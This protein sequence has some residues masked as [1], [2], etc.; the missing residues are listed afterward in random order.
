MIKIFTLYALSKKYIKH[1]IKLIFIL[2]INFK[3]WFIL[4]FMI[5]L[6][7]VIITMI[8]LSWPFLII[9]INDQKWR[10]LNIK[11]R[12]FLFLSVIKFAIKRMISKFVIF[13]LIIMKNIKIITSIII[14]QIKTYLKSLLFLKTSNKTEPSN[15]LIKHF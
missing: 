10:S 15:D 5:S 4:I 9:E 12:F 3:I 2:K 14:A 7:L 6:H 11:M 13:A 8:N 1:F